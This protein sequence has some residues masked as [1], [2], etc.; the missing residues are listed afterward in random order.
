MNGDLKAG[1]SCEKACCCTPACDTALRQCC[2]GSEILVSSSPFKMPSKK[3]MTEDEYKEAIPGWLVSCHFEGKPE[4]YLVT[5][6]KTELSTV[7]LY[8]RYITLFRLTKTGKLQTSTGMLGPDWNTLG[9][10]KRVA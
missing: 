2:L 10:M 6:V 4:F 7:H 9:H 8:G 5:E 3:D 1:R